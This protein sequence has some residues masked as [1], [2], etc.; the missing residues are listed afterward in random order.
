MRFCSHC[1]VKIENDID[2]CPLCDMDTVKTDDDFEVAY[3]YIKNS[4]TRGAVLKLISFI[5]LAFVVASLLINHL[6]PTENSWAFITV[7]AIIYAWISVINV[8]RSATNPASI[9]L[10]QL[11][12]GGG[13]IFLIDFLSGWNRWSV[14]YVIPFMIIVAALAITLMIVIGSVKFRAYTIYLLAVVASGLFVVILWLCGCSTVEWPS[15]TSAFMC[16]LCF[17][18]ILVFS[19]RKTKNELEKRFHV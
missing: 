16:G 5:L 3:P 12:C 17:I 10:C 11:F 4:I 8:L 15:V 14:N 6:V 19:W 18:T 2:K 9:V 7:A 13:L 1:N